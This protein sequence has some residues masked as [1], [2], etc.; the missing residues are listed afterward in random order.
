MLNDT[1]RCYGEHADKGY[2]KSAENFSVSLK[3]VTGD[4][5]KVY[6]LYAATDDF[7]VELTPSKGLSVRDVFFKGKPM[8]WEPPLDTLPDPERIDMNAPLLINGSKVDGTF[9]AACFASHIEMM[10]LENWGMPVERNGRFFPLH[11]NVSN[12]PVTEVSIALSPEKVM[13]SGSFLVY[14]AAGI[15]IQPPGPP[16][17]F[18]ITKSVEVSAREPSIFLKD[19][20]TNVSG[21]ARFPDWGYHIQLRP[22]PGCR[23]LVPSKHL[24]LRGGGQVPRDHEEWRPA[25]NSAVRIETGI[26]H[27]DLLCG[28]VFPDGS[29]GVKSLL[30]YSDGSGIICIIPP[31]PYTQSWS[32]RGGGDGS[33]FQFLPRD[34]GA[35]GRIFSKNWDGVGPEIGASD[36]D[37]EGDIDPAILQKELDPG[38]SVTLP[39][40]LRFAGNEEA[41]RLQT[42]IDAYTADRVTTS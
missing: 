38:E 5:E 31:S 26:I 28:P 36:L 6:R 13:I 11:G 9:W 21:E 3:H 16:P 4:P 17:K 27:K 15:H 2:N 29:P 25:E 30:R 24:K 8:F 19:T 33:E 42:E 39:V 20:I 35:P 7:S 22:E 40:Y 10:G 18:K 41:R 12:T 1:I 14:D 23:Y 32:S 34:G 37:H